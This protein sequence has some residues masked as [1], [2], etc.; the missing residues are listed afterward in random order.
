MHLLI[1]NYGS[2]CLSLIFIGFVL[3]CGDGE[4]ESSIKKIHL[5]KI[6]NIVTLRFNIYSNFTLEIPVLAHVNSLS[7]VSDNFPYRFII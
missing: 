6:K 4:K 2:Y 3:V 5:F 7:Y 1:R